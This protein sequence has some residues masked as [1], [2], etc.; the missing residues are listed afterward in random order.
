MNNENEDKD[1]PLGDEENIEAISDHIEKHIGEIHKA[2]HEIVSEI[3]HIDLHWVKPSEAYPFNILVSSGM[4][5]LPMI[6][7]EKL[8]AEETRQYAELCFILPEDWK[9]E[10]ANESLP[11]PLEDENNYW[12]LRWTKIL[13]RFPHQAETWLGVGH[14]IP[15]SKELD[16]YS[17]DNKLCCMFLFSPV[18]LPEEFFK[19]TTDKGKQ[20]RFLNM[21]PLY[22]EEMEYKIQ[23]GTDKLVD[24]FIKYG[25]SDVLDINRVNTCKKGFSLKFWKK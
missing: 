22:K 13:A 2:F 7:P 15:T 19:L 5:D 4:S 3:V 14:T 23:N 18:T 10:A 12:P 20:I 11:N 21:I 1:L 24:K 8:E 25:V 6:V 17:D 9:M 16:S